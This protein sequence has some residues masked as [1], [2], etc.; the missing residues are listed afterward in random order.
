VNTEALSIVGPEALPAIAELC[1]RAIV[2]PPT[3]PELQKTLFAVDQPATVRFDPDI[4]ILATVRQGANGAVRLLATDPARRRRGH[5]HALVV[6]AEADLAG[7]GDITFG[8]DPPYFLYPGV[9]T[10][11]TWLCYLLE[12]H[13]YAR[14]ETNY[15]VSVDLAA[16][17]EGPGDSLTPDDLDRSE[18]DAWATEH[19]PNWHP[20]LLRA[21]DQ[22]GLAI[23]RD[24][25]GIAS[26]CAYDVNRSAT[27][28]PVA[29]RPDLIG[30]GAS[31][32]LLLDAL[33]RMRR[34]GHRRIEVLWV[35][36]LIPYARVG[37]VIGPTFFVYRKRL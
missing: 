5:G 16:V 9:P 17:P 20:E 19:W 13:H 4:G 8:A 24:H 26:V 23:T 37:G 29:S 1:E 11:E 34:D 6:Q 10:T 18:L 36:P 32:G 35:G 12:R 22:G 3:G 28:G 30:K 14:A 21:F 31:R 2:R 33:N 25:F 15:N 27:L 7:A